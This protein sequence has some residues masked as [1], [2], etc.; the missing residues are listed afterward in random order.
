MDISEYVVLIG[1][2][3]SFLFFTEQGKAI[4]AKFKNILPSWLG[5][6]KSNTSDSG[7]N[8]LLK[9]AELWEQLNERVDDPIAKKLLNDLWPQLNKKPKGEG[10]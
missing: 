2:A 7:D 6:I 1:G 3:I 9:R 4:L 10:V 8:T 5:G